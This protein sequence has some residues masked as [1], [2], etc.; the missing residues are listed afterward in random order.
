MSSSTTTMS[1]TTGIVSLLGTTGVIVCENETMVWTGKAS[2]SSLTVVRN[3]LSTGVAHSG[4]APVACVMTAYQFNAHSSALTQIET[5]LGKSSSSHFPLPN[6]SLGGYGAG[7]TRWRTVTA[8]DFTDGTS[9]LKKLSDQTVGATATAI[10][11]T[12]IPQTYKHLLLTCSVRDTGSAAVNWWPL[13]VN[14]DTTTNNKYTQLLYGNGSTMAA[15]EYLT[16]P[17]LV[18]NWIPAVSAPA[19]QFG[20]SFMFI[21]FYTN[22]TNH[23]E[24]LYVLGAKWGTAA[25]TMAVGQYYAVSTDTAPITALYI[26]PALAQYSNVTLYGIPG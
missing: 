7:Q 14:G 1:L 11:I 17:Y 16:S 15:A 21:P 22:A 8:N 3:L 18:F 4:G 2:G 6:L 13:Y 5:K 10:N 19:A 12:G 24:F 23:K 20:H 9:I 26:S 25:G